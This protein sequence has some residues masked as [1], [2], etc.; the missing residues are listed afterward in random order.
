MSE[1]WQERKSRRVGIKAWVEKSIGITSTRVTKRRRSPRVLHNAAVLLWQFFDINKRKKFLPD[2]ARAATD[3][4]HLG[5]GRGG[6]NGLEEP[7]EP[8]HDRWDIHE[9]LA[10]LER[11]GF[12][13]FIDKSETMK[14]VT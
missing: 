11:R 2:R 7:E 10:R 9:E 8:A 4:F 5:K 12:Q 3:D 13:G 14:R 6:Q 1:V